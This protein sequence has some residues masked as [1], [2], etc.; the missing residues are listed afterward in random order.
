[1]I[2]L[3]SATLTMS[4]VI[5][6]IF[7]IKI[8]SYI[9]NSQSRLYSPVGWVWVYISVIGNQFVDNLFDV[10][11]LKRIDPDEIPYKIFF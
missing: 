2:G 8:Y 10:R 5:S 11:S 6:I 1:M 4:L 9:Y 7:E 3:F